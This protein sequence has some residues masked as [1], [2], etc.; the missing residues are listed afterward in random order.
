MVEFALILF[1]L[2]ILVVG[3]I[4]F[5]IALELLARPNRLANQGARWAVVNAYPGCTTRARKNARSRAAEPTTLQRYIACSRLP[6]ALRPTVD[7]S[8]P[9]GRQVPSGIRCEV[10]VSS[11][12]SFSGD[13][14][15]WHHT[16]AARTTM[17]IEQ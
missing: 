1:P 5:G 6:N 8:F 11:P 13:H 7:I 14:G 10:K 9:T 12:Y 3:I 15:T 2:L 17:R 16:L 4:Q